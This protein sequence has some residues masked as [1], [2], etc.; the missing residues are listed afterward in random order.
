[1]ID[2]SLFVLSILPRKVLK[3]NARDYPLPKKFIAFTLLTQKK[4]ATG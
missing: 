3:K 4:G 2:E 1:L